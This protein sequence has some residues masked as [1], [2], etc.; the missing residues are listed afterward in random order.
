MA[1]PRGHGAAIGSLARA[2]YNAASMRSMTGYG[3]AQGK[4]G[5]VALTVEVRSVNQRHLDVKIVAPREY[6]VWESDWRREVGRRV[7]RGRVEVYVTRAAATASRSVSVNKKVAAAH[8][9]AWRELKRSFDLQGAIEL[10]LLQG[11]P[12]IFQSA[13]AEVDPASE[14]R[15]AN[16]VLRKALLAHEKDRS[17]EGAHLARDLARHSKRLGVLIRR[18]RVRVADL[19]PRIAQRLEQ[20][21]VKLLDGR[22]VDPAR[23]AQEAALVA[24]RADVSE[25]IVRLQSHLEALDVLV[26]EREPVGKRI[27]F[28]LQEIQRELNTIGSKASDLDVTKIVL[29]GKATLEKIREQVQ[30]VE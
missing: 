5:A 7:S 8:V 17:R 15:L 20:R 6:A 30:N 24:D 4:A 12:D 9:E 22:E 18:L 26:Q 28:L 25:E 21:L 27:E 16:G 2:D 11:R 13:A 23:I 29:E 19:G 3:A 10:A 14:G 1:T